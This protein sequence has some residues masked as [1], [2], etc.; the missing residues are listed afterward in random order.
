MK[1]IKILNGFLFNRFTIENKIAFYINE[2]Y[3][4]DHYFNVMDKLDPSKFDVIF[5]N[6]FK[7][8]KYK[9]ITEKIKSKP[10]NILFLNQVIWV[11]KYKLLVTHIYL[12]GDSIKKISLADKI[13]TLIYKILIVVGRKDKTKPRKQYFQQVLGVYNVRFMYGADGNRFKLPEYN[14]L[15]DEF[16]CHGPRDSKIVHEQFKKPITQM[17]YPRYDTYFSNLSNQKL[18]NNLYSQHSC[19]RDKPTIL[20]ICT[21]SSHFSTIEKYEKMM[22]KLIDKY[23]VILRPHPMEIDPQFSRYNPNVHQIINSR[24]FIVNIDAHQEMSELYLIADYVFCDYGGSIF[25]SLYLDKKILLMDHEDIS[26]DE[27][28]FNSTQIEVRKYLP[29][30]NFN[31]PIVVEEDFANPLFWKKWQDSQAYARNKYFGDNKSNSSLKAAKR[32]LEILENV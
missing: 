9:K 29:V 8:V 3:I 26:L 17:G 13:R 2:D 14:S 20:W 31:D 25:S 1:I 32:M 12:G 4:L 15:F 5:A 23:N 18:K 21:V 28:M 7:D 6:K 27:E 19:S 30:I 16:F 24:K 10:W 11:R 22:L